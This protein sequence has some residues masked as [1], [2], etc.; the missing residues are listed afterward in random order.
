MTEEEI[1]WR[2]EVEEYLGEYWH[3]TG[4]PD[5][6]NDV[7]DSVLEVYPV[8]DINTNHAEQIFGEAF[9]FLQTHCTSAVSSKDLEFMAL[10]EK[11]RLLTMT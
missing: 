3:L 9:A 8:Q 4:R 11:E 6:F 5:L 1:T 7:V 2:K 10:A